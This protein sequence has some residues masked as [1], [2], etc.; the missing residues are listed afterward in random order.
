MASV[1]RPA[2]IRIDEAY[3]ALLELA[4]QLCYHPM[5]EYTQ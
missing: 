2:S 4:W 5:Y 3:C 1:W